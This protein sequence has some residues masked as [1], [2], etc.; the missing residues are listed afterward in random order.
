M[1]ERKADL[2]AKLRNPKTIT[3]SQG[4]RMIELCNDV[5]ARQEDMAFV[6]WRKRCRYS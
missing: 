4:K 5:N 2:V 1:T 6:H 3:K